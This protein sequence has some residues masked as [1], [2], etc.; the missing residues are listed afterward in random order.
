LDARADAHV[1][2]VE[3]QLQW[4]AAVATPLEQQAAARG[5]VVNLA[6]ALQASTLLQHAAAFSADGDS[7]SG[8]GGA[9]AAHVAALFCAAKLASGGAA[10]VHYGTLPVGCKEASPHALAAIINRHTP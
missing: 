3:Q 9:A 7:R 6:R 2:E 10:R 8:N 5:L 1:L 4:A